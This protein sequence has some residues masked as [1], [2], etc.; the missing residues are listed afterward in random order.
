MRKMKKIAAILGGA[1]C[2]GAVAIGS[3]GLASV[4]FPSDPAHASPPGFST[5]SA[6]NTCQGNSPNCKPPKNTNNFGTVEVTIE[7]IGPKGALK[8]G[9][10]PDNKVT[11]TSTE[12]GPGKGKC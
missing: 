7:T 10:T 11:V 12:C 2:V 9:N 8:N 1:A 4:G 5:E 3:V 6:T